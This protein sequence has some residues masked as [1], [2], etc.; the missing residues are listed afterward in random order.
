MANQQGGV[1]FRRIKGKVVPIKTGPGGA[2]AQRKRKKGGSKMKKAAGVAGA[3]GA[4]VGG[5]IALRRGKAMSSLKRSLQASEHTRF[6]KEGS[7]GVMPKVKKGASVKRKKKKL[8][9]G[10]S[11]GLG[12]DI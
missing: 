7:F 5:A 8:K 6:A 3:V 4:V 10:W 2:A 9:K 12:V 1:T 11:R